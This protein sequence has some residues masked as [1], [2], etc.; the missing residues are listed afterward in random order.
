MKSS[1][2][3]YLSLMMALPMMGK[4]DVVFDLL[5]NSAIY[6]VLDGQSTA[7][8]T[9]GSL[10]ATLSSSEGTLNRTASGFGMN[11]PGSDDTDALNLDQYIDITFDQTVRFKN[12]NVSSWGSGS[13][14]EIRLGSN[15]VYTA[16]GTISTTGNA[17]FDFRISGGQTVRI[18]ATGETTPTNGF[19][20]DGFSVEAIPEPAVISFIA[21]ISL[22]S[23]AIR[24][25]FN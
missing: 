7:S 20:F 19:S 24:R 11:G 2:I 5:G 17:P 4:S 3:V 16:M 12:V 1:G 9:N 6:S 21:L 10:I 18:Y 8:V 23:L 14:A 22:G 25:M 13:S 15:D